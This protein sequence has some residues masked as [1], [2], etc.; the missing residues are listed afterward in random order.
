MFKNQLNQPLPRFFY[1]GVVG[2]T[3]SYSTQS[4]ASKKLERGLFRVSTRFQFDSAGAS[5]G[6][7]IDGG[8]NGVQLI[9]GVGDSSSFAWIQT[10]QTNVSTSF[11]RFVYPGDSI[12]VVCNGSDIIVPQTGIMISGTT[13]HF[14][15]RVGQI[16]SGTPEA[17]VGYSITKLVEQN[18]LA[19]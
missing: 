13:L 3:A 17:T 6:T 4:I 8:F 1:S 19:A 14:L 12:V 7:G 18:P 9:G 5:F 16:L 11:Q 10:H 2:I 15:V